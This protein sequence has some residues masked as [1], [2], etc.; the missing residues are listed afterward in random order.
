MGGRKEPDIT[1]Q[2]FH[3]EAMAGCA[4]LLG[5]VQGA[6]LWAGQWRGHPTYTGDSAGGQAMGWAVERSPHTLGTVRGGGHIPWDL[7]GTVQRGASLLL[8]P[9]SP[10]GQTACHQTFPAEG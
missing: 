7:L 3:F 4:S 10:Q 8:H 6:R 1:E 5:T 2:L 9:T